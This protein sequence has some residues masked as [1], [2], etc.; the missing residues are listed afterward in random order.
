MSETRKNLAQISPDFNP[1]AFRVSER[2]G[3]LRKRRD[4]SDLD[5]GGPTSVYGRGTAVFAGKLGR[6]DEGNRLIKLRRNISFVPTVQ[7]RSDRHG[8]AMSRHRIPPTAFRLP[9]TDKP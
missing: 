4:C 7:M 6:Y 8:R 1:T 5:N 9:P 3:Y 2:R